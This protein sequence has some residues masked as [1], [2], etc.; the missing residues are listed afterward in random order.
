M[1]IAISAE[2]T[3]DLSKELL[4]KYNIEVIPFNV[5][6]G[7]H[8]APD[9]EITPEDIFKYVDETRQLPKT[10][11]I[12]T[13]EY[14]EYFQSLK[15]KYDAVIHFCLS[16]QLSCSFANATNA[17]SNLD[18]VYVIDT[19]HL[20]TGIA[21]LAIYARTLADKGEEPTNIVKLV[22]KRIPYV[23]TSFVVNTLN[24]LHKGGRCSGLAKFGAMILRVKPQ[25][26]L[27]DGKMVPGKKYFGK[28]IHTVNEYVKDTLNEFD[29]PDLDIVF[30]THTHATI[31]MV[32]ACVN[33][34]KEKGFKNIYETTA[35]ATI[36]SHCGPKTIGIL[37]FNDG[38]LKK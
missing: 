15:N 37:Y 36:T 31:E 10:S 2:S 34:L 22:N 16:S 30:V 19:K 3:I 8:S 11:A 7:E 35:G 24:Y 1:K 29:H 27:K 9:G 4:Q 6:L 5:L 17:A 38:D 23:Q 13:F 28:S 14:E 20:S 21:L 18:N 32:E 12:N 26:V 33:A 25:I